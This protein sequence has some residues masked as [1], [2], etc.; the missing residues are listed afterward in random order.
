[1]NF[2]IA[3]LLPLVMQLGEYIKQGLDHYATLKSV[4]E[5]HRVDLVASFLVVKLASWDP[6]VSGKHILDDA[7]RQAGA[8][9]LAGIIVNMAR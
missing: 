1:M 4:P 7:T 6:V 2:N 9:F 3:T 8:R 5:T